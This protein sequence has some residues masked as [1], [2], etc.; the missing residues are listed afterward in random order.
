LDEKR[1]M[2]DDEMRI[3]E[4]NLEPPRDSRASRMSD[5]DRK[6]SE[7]NERK[8]K[9]D[10]RKKKLQDQRKEEDKQLKENEKE[11]DNTV[12]MKKKK[13]Y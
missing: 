10:E 13:G 12:E 4:M 5:A 1:K 8:R 7:I 2:E 3:D 9:L 11:V 6:M